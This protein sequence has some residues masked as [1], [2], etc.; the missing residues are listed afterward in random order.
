L[1]KKKRIAAIAPGRATKPK[2]CRHPQC[3]ATNPPTAIDE[4]DA[5][6]LF[7]SGEAWGLRVVLIDDPA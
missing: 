1:T 4:V 6:A 3:W 7:E 2:A 5:D